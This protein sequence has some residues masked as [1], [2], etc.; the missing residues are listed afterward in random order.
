MRLSRFGG[1]QVVGM[2]IVIF[3]C[4]RLGL[5]WFGRRRRRRWRRGIASVGSVSSKRGK[6]GRIGDKWSSLRDSE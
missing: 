2:M 5:R 4:M 6:N 1:G 3:G